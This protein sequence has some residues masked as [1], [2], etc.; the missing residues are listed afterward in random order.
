MKEGTYF[1]WVGMDRVE[2]NFN[3]TVGICVGDGAY[4][5]LTYRKSD[6]EVS[7]DVSGGSLVIEPRASNCAR[8][9]VAR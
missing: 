1:R 9:K 8:I 6:G 2:L 5:E 7:L 4:I 3:D